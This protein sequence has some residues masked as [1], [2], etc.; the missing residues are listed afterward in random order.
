MFKV[1][2]DYQ[3]FENLVNYEMSKT[4]LEQALKND[5]FE[6]LVNYEMSKTSN[7]LV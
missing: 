4:E 6:N 2:L 3:V 7:L 5:K 1:L